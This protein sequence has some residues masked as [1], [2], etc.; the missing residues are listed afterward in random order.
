VAVLPDPLASGQF[1]SATATD[2]NNNTSE[3][4]SDILVQ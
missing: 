4:S 2:P 1:I 3:F